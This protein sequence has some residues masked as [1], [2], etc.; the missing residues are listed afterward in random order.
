MVNGEEFLN[1]YPKQRTEL[2]P[3]YREIYHQHYQ[4]NRHARTRASRA[5][6]CL[7]GWMHKKVAAVSPPG[8]SGTLEI[9]AGTLNQLSYES[10]SGFYDIVEPYEFLYR[11]S[12]NLGRIR[13]IYKDISEIN[14]GNEYGRITSIAVLEHIL[15]LPEVIARSAL[16]LRAEGIFQAAIPSEGTWLW[17]L[18]TRYTGH[19]FKK[20]YGLDYQVL[21]KYEHVNDAGEIEKVLAYFFEK[22]KCRVF[23][24][25]K[26]VSFYRYYEC[27]QPDRE[28][29]QRFIKEKHTLSGYNDDQL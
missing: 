25:S 16:L 21:M 15:N 12:G 4:S 22:I 17:K 19:E 3:A 23:G 18:G 11:D 9:G 7:E 5:S 8:E 10:P 20:K 13:N 2:P 6:S 14:S 26:S 28:K 24:L 27:L 1:K 29:V